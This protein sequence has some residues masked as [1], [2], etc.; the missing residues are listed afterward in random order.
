MTNIYQRWLGMIV[1]VVVIIV[2]FLF[3]SRTRV[4]LRP[5]VSPS[6]AGEIELRHISRSQLPAVFPDDFPFEKD[7]LVTDSFTT[8]AGENGIQYVFQFISKNGLDENLKLYEDYL[9]KNQW[10]VVNKFSSG[11]T[12]A[13]SARQLDQ[14]VSLQITISRN[15][16]TGDVSVQLRY[17]PLPK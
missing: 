2:S 10:S 14:E 16:V 17:L 9:N 15:Q 3:L 6:P 5:T 4:D 1:I 8:K 12:R 7:V 13:L 11:G